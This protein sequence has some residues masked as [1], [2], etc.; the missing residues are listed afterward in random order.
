ML[1][2][3]PL[4]EDTSLPLSALDHSGNPWLV[5]A[6]LHSLPFIHIDAIPQCVCVFMWHSPLS[7][8]NTNHTGLK[9]HFNLIIPT[10]TL[11]P[12]KDMF[13]GTRD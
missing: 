11:F 8:K 9:A 10:K 1:S 6:E 5:T 12:N 13:T 4:R 3:K 7:Y 2:Q